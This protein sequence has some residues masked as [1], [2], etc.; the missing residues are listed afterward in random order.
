[1]PLPARTLSLAAAVAALFY[2]SAFLT[3]QPSVTTEYSKH[4]TALGNL[5]VSVA[6]AMPA[7]KYSYRPHPD[8]MNFSELMVHIATTNYQFCAGLMDGQT[9]PLPAASGKDDIVKFLADSFHYC[10]EVIDHLSESQLAA[11][12][13]SPDGKLPGREL[14]LA[15]FVHV[16]HHR[17]QAEIYLRNNG[18]VPPRYRI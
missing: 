12:H 8:S 7:E 10:S 16:A 9:P 6:Q 5:S 2:S 15:M 3:D 14:L 4:L 11:I 13:D 18:I 17:G 1:M